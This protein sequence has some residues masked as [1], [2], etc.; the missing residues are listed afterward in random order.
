MQICNSV[1]ENS[2][3]YHSPGS[4]ETVDGGC[5]HSVV[6][7]NPDHEGVGQ[8]GQQSSHHPNHHS[9]PHLHQGATSWK[10]D[11]QGILAV[12]KKRIHTTSISKFQA[13]FYGRQKEGYIYFHFSTDFFQL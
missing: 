12:F 10:I 5:P 1:P 13:N 7:P 8:V 4:P 11:K 3:R 9:L 2:D 6:Y